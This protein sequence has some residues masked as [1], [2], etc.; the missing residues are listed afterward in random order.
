MVKVKV[1]SKPGAWACVRAAAIDPETGVAQT[2]ESA[3]VPEGTVFELREPVMKKDANGVPQFVYNDKG[4]P[5]FTTDP[6]EI[7]RCFQVVEPVEAKPE[8]KKPGPKPK[9]EQAALVEDDE[10]KAES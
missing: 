8:R 9:A 3:F 4:F 1:I 5:V 6:P 2:W 7:S 10:T